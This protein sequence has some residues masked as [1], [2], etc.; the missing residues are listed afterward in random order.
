MSRTHTL[1]RRPVVPAPRRPSEEGIFFRDV[2]R[3]YD[4]CTTAL[5]TDTPSPGAG[6]TIELRE[7]LRY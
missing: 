1:P 4:I 3:M 7:P 2:L 5:K 6:E